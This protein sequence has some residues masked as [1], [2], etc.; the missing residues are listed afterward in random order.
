MS[1][2][3]SLV[4]AASV[5]ALRS[6]PELR[7]LMVRRATRSRSWA[8]V[9]V[10]P[11]GR[12]EPGEDVAVAAARE[13]FEE[14]GLLLAEADPDELARL[15]GLRSAIHAGD[16]DFLAA[17]EDHGA[18]F[19]RNTLVPVSRWLTPSLEKRR[20]DAHFYLSDVSFFGAR[21]LDAAV[22][23]ASETVDER[24]WVPSEVLDAYSQAELELAPPT[25]RHL[26]DLAEWGTTSVALA[27]ARRRAIE[28]ILPRIL[29]DDRK[30]IL[31][32]WDPEYPGT[33][34]EGVTWEQTTSLYGPSRFVLAD[35]RWRSVDP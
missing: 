12:I 2:S 19:D 25:L 24:W 28:P 1:L 9:W 20:F 11:G 31:L 4:P 13:L 30:C 14:T 32:P 18:S 5:L 7:V 35:G 27:G 29:P 15:E 3:A 22:A 33:A 17:L 6:D 23:D 8:G 10:F 21:R 16:V 26:E 34:G